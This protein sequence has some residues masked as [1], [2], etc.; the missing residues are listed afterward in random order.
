MDSLIV[1]ARRF[2]SDVQD[3]T[4]SLSYVLARDYYSVDNP[5]GS[6]PNRE[7]FENQKTNLLEIRT[8]INRAYQVRGEIRFAMDNFDQFTGVASGQLEEAWQQ[9]ESIINGLLRSA[10]EIRRDPNAS[11]PAPPR[12]PA[13]PLQRVGTRPIIHPPAQRQERFNILTDV[14]RLALDNVVILHRQPPENGYDHY[15]LVGFTATMPSPEG[16][17][18]VT[19]EKIR[20]TFTAPERVEYVEVYERYYASGE[21][22]PYPTTMPCGRQVGGRY[23]LIGGEVNMSLSVTPGAHL[24][25]VIKRLL[26]TV[27]QGWSAVAATVEGSVRYSS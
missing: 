3:G 6:L 27:G 8:Q 9:N 5:P 12:F 1:Q 22:P 20:L 24:Y 4:S 21:F 15:L 11:L 10:A 23:P 14:F 16:V 7:V 25:I 18:S 17:S 13:L 26:H 2:F 19:L